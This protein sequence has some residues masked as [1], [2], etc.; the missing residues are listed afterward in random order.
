MFLLDTHLA[1]KGYKVYNLETKLVIVSKDVI[2]H[3]HFF[4]Y[5]I[6]HDKEKK[7]AIGQ[8]FLPKCSQDYHDYL[9]YPNLDPY[10]K[11]LNISDNHT[12]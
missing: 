8:L 7:H 6:I 9:D 2:F 12:I 1:K 10:D 5:Q 11:V 4:P 3:E